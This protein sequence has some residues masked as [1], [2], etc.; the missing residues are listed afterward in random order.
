[1]FA[2][3]I[4]LTFKPNNAPSETIPCKR[5]R[6][7]ATHNGVEWVA[8]ID[9]EKDDDSFMRIRAV[10]LLFSVIGDFVIAR[11]LEETIYSASLTRGLVY[12]RKLTQLVHSISLNPQLVSK[13][14]N[15][16]LVLL[17]DTTLSVGT[18]VETWWI[19]HMQKLSYQRMVLAEREIYEQ[20]ELTQ[21]DNS[22]AVFVCFKCHSKSIETEQKQTRGA[23]EA[24]TVFCKC[25]N[26]DTRWRM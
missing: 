18:P 10:Q 15:N 20:D 12:G 14:N 17:D 5:K 7:Y 25:R 22:T 11:S 4:S 6:N 8:P 3:T 16:T 24:M 1:M 9:I 26:C 23:D 19:E 13:Y 2:P 21:T